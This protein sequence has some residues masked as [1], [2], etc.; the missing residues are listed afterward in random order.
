MSISTGE[1]SREQIRFNK[2]CDGNSIEALR[3]YLLSEGE[4]CDEEINGQVEIPVSGN[5]LAGEF[6]RSKM[7]SLSNDGV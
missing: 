3:D 6:I 2:V 7:L 1:D 5:M 4:D